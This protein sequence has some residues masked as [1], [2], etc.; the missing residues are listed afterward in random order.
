MQA[1]E[2]L[3]VA[4]EG[5]VPGIAGH[6]RRVAGYAAELARGIGLS[7]EEEIRL[8]RAGVVHDIGKA[9]VPGSI[10]NKPGPLTPQ[11]ERLV[12]QHP[13]TGAAM[14]SDLGDPDLAAF[15]RHHHERFDGDGY[16]DG[17]AGAAIP[18][19]A[20]ILAVVDT[21]DALTSHRPYRRAVSRARALEILH[22]EAGTRLDPDLVAHFGS[23]HAGFAVA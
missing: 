6:S 11:E 2:R 1:L 3:A 22:R 8:A 14:V 17:L 12:R 13:A 7:H 15:V 23:R 16:P 21:F 18:L 19:G 20:R 9:C 5:R 10:L 4:L